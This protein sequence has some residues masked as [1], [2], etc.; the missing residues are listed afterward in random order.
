[1]PIA[2]IQFVNREW[3]KPNRTEQKPL[4]VINVT[5]KNIEWRKK[6]PDVE[7]NVRLLV[8]IRDWRK[9][10][11]TYFILFIYLHN[12]ISCIP[13]SLNSTRFSESPYLV[14]RNYSGYSDI[15]FFLIPS[16]GFRTVVPYQR[17]G[18]VTPPTPGRRSVGAPGRR[19]VVEYCG[20]VS[21]LANFKRNPELVRLPD[22]WGSLRWHQLAMGKGKG[23]DG[24]DG[25][26]NPEG[27]GHDNKMAFDLVY[28][29]YISFFIS[30]ILH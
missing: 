11:T 17:C 9:R 27:N 2:S 28:L 1:M 16:A 29:V 26:Q 8:T 23:R 14:A 21:L 24:E 5:L 4:V 15:I 18:T 22:T 30:N 7:W 12:G 19:D 6:G 25:N 10:R 13:T 3:G 20:R